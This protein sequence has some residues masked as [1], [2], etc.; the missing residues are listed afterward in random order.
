MDQPGRV[1]RRGDTDGDGKAGDCHGWNFTTNSPDIDN[2]SYGTHGASVS[3]VVGARVGNGTGTAGVAPDVTIMPLVIG[4]GSSVDMTSASRPSATPSTT[5]PTSSTPP[6]AVA[7]AAGPS[8]TC[9]P[10][11]R[12]PAANGVLVVA[13]AG[14]DARDRDASPMYPRQPDRDGTW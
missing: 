2:G 13:A 7:R 3:G 1:L 5:A 4:S 9:G 6:G 14:N 8:T 12:T 10:P 11:S